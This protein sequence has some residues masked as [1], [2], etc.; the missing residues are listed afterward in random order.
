M[1]IKD[2]HNTKIAEIVSK[3]QHPHTALE[4]GEGRR[5]TPSNEAATLQV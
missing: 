4:E 5:Q 2:K 1:K 3:K